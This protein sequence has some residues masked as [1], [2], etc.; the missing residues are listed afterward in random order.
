[1][2]YGLSFILAGLLLVELR[3]SVAQESAPQEPAE[4]RQIL[5]APT[6]FDFSGEEEEK[7]WVEEDTRLH[8]QPAERSPVLT[9]LA[10]AAELPVLERRQG[11]VRVRYGSWQGWTR[12]EGTAVGLPEIE[13]EPWWQPRSGPDP[14]RLERALTILAEDTSPAELG[15]YTLYTDLKDTKLLARL[16]ALAA[17]LPELFRQRFG[18][19]AVPGENESVVLYRSEASYQAYIKEQDPSAAGSLGHAVGEL[20]VLSAGNRRRDEVSSLLVHELTH[21][22]T[23]RALGPELPPWLVEGIAEDLA[24]CRVGSSGELLLGSLDGWRSTASVPVRGPDGQTQFMI[25][26]TR[27]GPS[28]ALEELRMRWRDGEL[29][30]LAE[31]VDLPREEFLDLERRRIH[32]SMSAFLVRYLLDTEMFNAGFRVYLGRVAAGD[33]GDGAQLLDELGTDWDA[34]QSGFTDWL[35][36]SAPQRRSPKR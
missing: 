14:E 28:A 17:Q 27:G 15:P 4:E 5:G 1:M 18:L 24:Y 35:A 10:A 22:L 29:P 12:P 25:T 23:Y 13:D 6:A 36:S 33:R 26:T 7:I 32:Y 31:F 3:I 2:R 16:A 8:R 9:R 21:L 19:I 11:W 30:P 34:V 20:A